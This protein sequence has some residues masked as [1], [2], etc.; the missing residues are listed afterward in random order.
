MKIP[1]T[2]ERARIFFLG[3]VSRKSENFII[4]E[5]RII[6]PN[7]PGLFEAKLNETEMAWEKISKIGIYSLSFQIFLSLGKMFHSDAVN[8]TGK[9]SGKHRFWLGGIEPE[10][11][12]ST[13]RK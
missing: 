2:W 8:A 1:E 11:L 6:R 5:T 12:N 10:A 7:V 4:F 3:R 13:A 9:E